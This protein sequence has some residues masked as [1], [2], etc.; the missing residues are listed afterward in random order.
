M[1]DGCE[2]GLLKHELSILNAGSSFFGI[3]FDSL[4]CGGFKAYLSEKIKVN[5]RGAIRVSK[6]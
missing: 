1:R 3:I 5:E 6:I 2:I 4:L